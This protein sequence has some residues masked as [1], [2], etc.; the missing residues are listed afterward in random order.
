ML[1]YDGRLGKHQTHINVRFSVESSLDPVIIRFQNLTLYHQNSSASIPFRNQD[2]LGNSGARLCNLGGAVL[3][4]RPM[5]IQPVRLRTTV[6]ARYN[7]PLRPAAKGLYN[8]L[9]L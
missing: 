3:S 9:P 6:D 2:R 1:I 5:S 8:E 4:V 7:D